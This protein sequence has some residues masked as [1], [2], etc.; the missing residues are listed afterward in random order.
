MKRYKNTRQPGKLRMFFIFILRKDL[1]T[2]V[3]IMCYLKFPHSNLLYGS[4]QA[5]AIPCRRHLQVPR[6]L[7]FTPEHPRMREAWFDIQPELR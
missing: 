2:A 6:S 7:A 1:A 4:L 3:P 5:I